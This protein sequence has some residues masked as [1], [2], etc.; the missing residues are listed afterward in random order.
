MRADFAPPS[1]RSEQGRQSKFNLGGKLVQ[2]DDAKVGLP[3]LGELRLQ[4][5][6]E[7]RLNTSQNELR[8]LPLQ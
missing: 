3:E 4:R 6:Q 7:F 8:I 1:G 5:T 2:S